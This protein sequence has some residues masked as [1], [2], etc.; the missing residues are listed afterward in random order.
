M[1][2]SGRLPIYSPGPFTL[3]N[4]C[5]NY[6]RSNCSQDVTKLTPVSPEVISRQA[7]INIGTIGHVAHG[8]STVVKA[9]SGVQTVRFKNELERN[10]TIKLGEYVTLSYKIFPPSK[11][12]Q[13]A[14]VKSTL[15]IC[16]LLVLFG[17]FISGR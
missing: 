6:S 5:G 3:L 4:V 11:V 12:R 15:A 1:A 10:I 7:T 14:L 8:K 17:V 16:F 9:I 2:A 13:A